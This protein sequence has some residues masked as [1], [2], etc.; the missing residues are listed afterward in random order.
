MGDYLGRCQLELT[1]D[2]VAE[3]HEHHRVGS[4]IDEGLEPS[5]HS[6]R[7]GTGGDPALWLVAIWVCHFVGIPD[8]E[9]GENREVMRV[10]AA[11]LF[12]ALAGQLAR[13]LDFGRSVTFA[14][15]GPICNGSGKEQ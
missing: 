15:D 11:S 5:G 13:P 3:W 4:G 7:F 1:C 9:S 8:M 14:E 12:R 10:G 2:I 6:V